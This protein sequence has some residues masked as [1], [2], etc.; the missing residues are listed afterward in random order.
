MQINIYNQ[1]KIKKIFLFDILKL[2]TYIYM[3]IQAIMSYHDHNDED[4]DDED[5]EDE[6]G[7]K[8]KR[9]MYIRYLLII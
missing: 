2:R 4:H 6:V 3:Y 5:H 8:R 7:H 1:I 9:Y